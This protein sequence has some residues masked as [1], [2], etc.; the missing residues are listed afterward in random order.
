VLGNGRLVG[1]R[2]PVELTESFTLAYRTALG[3]G[4]LGFG[5]GFLPQV[6]FLSRPV[7]VTIPWHLCG[8][9]R[10]GGYA[11]PF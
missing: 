1:S 4:P 2:V 11:Q 10:M 8:S 6:D 7:L 9:I 3:V 5:L